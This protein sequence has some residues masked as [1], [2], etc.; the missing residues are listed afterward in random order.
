MNFSE[1]IPYYTFILQNLEDY[2]PKIYEWLFSAIWQFL[3][4]DCR[5]QFYSKKLSVI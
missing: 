4:F 2:K 5:A 3:I 1:K